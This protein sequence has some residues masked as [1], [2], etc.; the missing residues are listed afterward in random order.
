MGR[1]NKLKEVLFLAAA[2]WVALSAMPYFIWVTQTGSLNLHAAFWLPAL[3]VLVWA[4][5][6]CMRWP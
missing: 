2:T 5:A 1:L 3:L 6:R 4:Q